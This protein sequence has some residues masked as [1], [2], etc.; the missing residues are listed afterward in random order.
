MGISKSRMKKVAPVTEE[1]VCSSGIHRDESH[2]F[3]PSNTKAS[4][5]R[6]SISRRAQA[7][8]N[9]EGQDSEFS[10][11]EEVDRILAECDNT[12]IS[13]NR[14][15][16]KMPMFGSKSLGLY[17]YAKGQDCNNVYS[18][19]TRDKNEINTAN[20]PT[21][22]HEKVRPPQDL[23]NCA[24]IESTATASGSGIGSGSSVA[25]PI[26]YDAS[27]EDLMNT[28]EREFG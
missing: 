11:A 15:S 28:I 25:L 4:Y 14:A 2:L 27:E 6:V 7:D 1:T 13:L 9:S 12:D 16:Y 10:V 23:L 17:Y 18:G 19:S 5:L 3:G 26:M 22:I 20:I 21:S 24:N 8:C